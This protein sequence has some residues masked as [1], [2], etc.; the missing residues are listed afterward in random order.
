MVAICQMKKYLIPLFVVSLFLIQ[1]PIIDS[2]PIPVYPDPK[3]NYHPPIYFTSAT[4]SFGYWLLFVF[5]LDF[6]IDILIT[7]V[8]LFILDKKRGSQKLL[9][10]DDFSRLYFIGSVLL[11]SLIGLLTEWFLGM[12]IGGLFITLGIIFLS[13]YFVAKKLFGLLP[14]QCIF[15]GIFAII[16]NSIT[17]IVIFAL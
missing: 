2:N 12:W 4:S 15:M 16:I 6:S 7:Y 11:I 9:F 1:L 10:F 14:H 17:W 13:F 3:P 8:G 5:L